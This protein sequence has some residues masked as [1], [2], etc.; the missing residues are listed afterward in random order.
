MWRTLRAP[1]GGSAGGG[2]GGKDD[3][4]CRITAPHALASVVAF[5]HDPR[6]FK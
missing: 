3:D 5:S 4:A 2:D 6:A 1:A